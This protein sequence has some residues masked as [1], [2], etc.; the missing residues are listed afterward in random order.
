MI[1]PG[2]GGNSMFHVGVNCMSNYPVLTGCMSA[3]LKLQ[4]NI[5]I[6][7]KDSFILPCHTI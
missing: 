2:E 3:S 5:I 1:Y 7:F 4:V 6:S